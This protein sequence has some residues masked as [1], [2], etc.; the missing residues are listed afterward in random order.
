ML[1][2]LINNTVAATSSALILAQ[3]HTPDTVFK[4]C[5]IA[6]F[7]SYVS[8]ALLLYAVVQ[9]RTNDDDIPHSPETAGYLHAA[10]QCLK[11]LEFCANSD[12]VAK[13]FLRTIEGHYYFL[14]RKSAETKPRQISDEVVEDSC[15]PPTSLEESGA[16][17]LQLLCHPLRRT[18]FTTNT[19]KTTNENDDDDDDDDDEEAEKN[20]DIV[21][22]ITEHNLKSTYP[23]DS[24]IARLVER[25]DV[26]YE[27]RLR[28]GI[29]RSRPLTRSGTSDSMLAGSAPLGIRSGR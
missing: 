22:T 4:H 27:D 2:L 3:M 17:L 29:A 16:M 14:S 20:N 7:Q 8:I 25:L 10:E 23:D 12:D 26:G 28:R 5:W 15:R 21:R 1:I 19:N 24:A 11:T 13:S 6:I 18:K 9:A